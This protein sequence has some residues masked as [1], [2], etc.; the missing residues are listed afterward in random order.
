[1]TYALD[2]KKPCYKV[3][4]TYSDEGRHIVFDNKWIYSGEIKAD[5]PFKLPIIELMQMENNIPVLLDKMQKSF[6][7]EDDKYDYIGQLL[8][9]SQ[10]YEYNSITGKT[11][12]SPNVI[13]KTNELVYI[14]STSK[15]YK[16]NQEA[17]LYDF[18]MVM[19]DE[20]KDGSKKDFIHSWEKAYLTGQLIGIIE[21]ASN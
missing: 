15:S 2:V 4:R 20:N 10:M 9:R 21:Y 18:Y 12:L 8:T 7:G 11:K 3:F 14:D 5:Q 6:I 17:S 1:M 16:S 13:V 19:L